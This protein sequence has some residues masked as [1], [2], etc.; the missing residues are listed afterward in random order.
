MIKFKTINTV[1]NLQ[2]GWGKWLWFTLTYSVEVFYSPFPSS[3]QKVSCFSLLIW[4]PQ[5]GAQNPDQPVWWCPHST[6]GPAAPGSSAAYRPYP[7]GSS[8]SRRRRERRRTNYGTR[9][10]F[11][12]LM[13]WCE[14]LIQ[15]SKLQLSCPRGQMDKAP[16]CIRRQPGFDPQWSYVVGPSQ[17][18]L[19]CLDCKKNV[20]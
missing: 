11:A 8:G 16:A 12:C 17:D 20:L 9:N 3:T 13:L 18:D 15:S 1:E 2:G 14:L 7:A 10:F 4:P 6:A 5:P 19:A